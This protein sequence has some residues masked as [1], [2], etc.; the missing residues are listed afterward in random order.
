[1]IYKRE[2]L[3]VG[4]LV[5]RLMLRY[6]LDRGLYVSVS[7]SGR[8]T[9]IFEKYEENWGENKWKYLIAMTGNEDVEIE[10]YVNDLIGYGLTTICVP[11]HEKDFYM[12]PENFPPGAI[13]LAHEEFEEDMR[14]C[15]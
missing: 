15:E 12:N 7:Y 13:Q 8:I 11:M 5:A 1:M 4:D 10:K 14:W 3:K 6:N 2:T 9:A